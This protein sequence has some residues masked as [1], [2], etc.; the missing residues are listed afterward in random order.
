LRSS[1]EEH[2]LALVD[3]I[4]RLFCDIVSAGKPSRIDC[5]KSGGKLEGQEAFT[6]KAKA[7][8]VSN[9]TVESGFSLFPPE[10]NWYNKKHKFIFSFQEGQSCL[11][12]K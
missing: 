10:I 2:R 4:F 6:E 5:G 7:S 1:L 12:V 3:C 9:E 11:I 8:S